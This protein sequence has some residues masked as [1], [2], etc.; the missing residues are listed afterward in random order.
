MYDIAFPISRSRFYEEA[1]ADT[2][3]CYRYLPI[4]LY[5]ITQLY[6]AYFH[7]GKALDLP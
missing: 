2:L 3:R 6:N 4:V 1:E 5:I 7:D